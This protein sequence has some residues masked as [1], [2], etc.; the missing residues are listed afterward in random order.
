MKVINKSAIANSSI[1]P[2]TITTAKKMV[3]KSEPPH[4]TNFTATTKLNKSNI[5]ANLLTKIEPTEQKM[6][7]IPMSDYLEMVKELRELKERIGRL[8]EHCEKTSGFIP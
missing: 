7:Q 8:E 2:A 1:S 3:I 6:V 4:L 5:N